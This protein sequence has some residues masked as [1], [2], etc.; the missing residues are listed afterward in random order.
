[1]LALLTATCLFASAQYPE[2]YIARAE[3]AIQAAYKTLHD[4]GVGEPYRLE[5]A[6]S[7]G[8]F[9]EVRVL[10]GKDDWYDL[11]VLPSR[12]VYQISRWGQSYDQ[13]DLGHELIDARNPLVLE[14]SRQF[15]KQLK[16]RFDVVD[17]SLAQQ[18]TGQVWVSG[19]VRM[20]GRRVLNASR[21]IGVSFM[22]VSGKLLS[23]LLDPGLPAPP[24][25]TPKITLEQAREV[26]K[27][28]MEGKVPIHEGPSRYRRAK[29]DRHDELGYYLI[30]RQ[31]KMR[32]V[33]YVGYT[34]VQINSWT[35][36][37]TLSGVY[38]GGGPNDESVQG[39]LAIDALTGEPLAFVTD[40]GRREDLLVAPFKDERIAE[41]RFYDHTKDRVGH[42]VF[43]P[44][45]DQLAVLSGAAV[46]GDEALASA[47]NFLRKGDLELRILEFV[48]ASKDGPAFWSIGFGSGEGWCFVNTDV[49][50]KVVRLNGKDLPA[51]SQPSPQS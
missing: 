23:A 46:H 11:L 12:S 30:D 34:A 45:P 37:T 19:R 33:W 7:L 3:P 38:L 36:P 41:F 31:S 8:I 35:S 16:E 44:E 26:A 43:T 15:L 39:G 13:A 24:P 10:A 18:P 22:P 50:G 28:A 27:S 49:R 9:K 1:M 32:L 21:D 40:R 17:P 4:F 42:T 14:R 48:P 2:S 6:A 29:A 5:R 25:E 47:I 20:N 51:K